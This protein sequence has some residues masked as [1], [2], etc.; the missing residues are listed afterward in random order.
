MYLQKFRLGLFFALLEMASYGKTWTSVKLMQNC[1]NCKNP[2]Y[3]K[4]HALHEN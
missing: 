2:R 3:A 1:D 4:V